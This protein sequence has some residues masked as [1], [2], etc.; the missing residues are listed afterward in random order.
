MTRIRTLKLSHWIAL[1]LLVLSLVVGFARGVY[2]I[3]DGTWWPF[4][5]VVF[6]CWPLLAFTVWVA[7]AVVLAVTLA[8]QLTAMGVIGSEPA[9]HPLSHSLQTSRA[10]VGLSHEQA[11][12]GCH[13]PVR[14][15]AATAN[16]C[17]E[18][19]AAEDS[20]PALAGAGR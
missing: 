5:P 11:E 19:E 8:L 13:E 14:Q 16:P 6:D 3:A 20:E 18:P 10:A 17:L 4:G 1:D 2:A 12:N 7:I 9:G 15:E